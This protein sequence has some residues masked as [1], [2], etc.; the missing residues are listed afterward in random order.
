MSKSKII[1]ELYRD[2]R[3]VE[4]I[5]NICNQ[6]DCEDVRQEL[7]LILL[8]KNDDLIESLHEQK[9]LFFYSIR[10]IMNLESMIRKGK[11]KAFGLLDADYHD[12]Q[13]EDFSGAIIEEYNKMQM[14]QSNGFPYHKALIELIVEHGSQRKVASITGIPLKSICNHVKAVR[15]YLQEKI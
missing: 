9:K 15:E 8:S 7:F 4:C 6:Q 12:R 2:K 14:N 11:K 5:A 13:E 3:V 1:D 10:V